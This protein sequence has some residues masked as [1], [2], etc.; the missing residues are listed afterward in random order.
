[1][2]K[3]LYEVGYEFQIYDLIL[4]APLGLLIYSILFPKILPWYYSHFRL[5]GAKIWMQNNPNKTITDFAKSKKFRHSRNTFMI[6]SILLFLLCAKKEIDEFKSILIPYKNGNY[7]I[8][9]GYV[10]NFNLSTD[11]KK[12][13][14]EY[15]KFT[16]NKVNFNYTNCSTI[17]GYSHTRSNGGVIRK[18]GQ[19]LKIGYIPYH[20]SSVIVLIEELN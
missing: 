1:M 6:I 9:N 4:L 16:L 15:E 5:R 3:I 17:L 13:W 8:V 11:K 7:K 2:T 20:G 19:H 18:N 14:I 12:S 10:E